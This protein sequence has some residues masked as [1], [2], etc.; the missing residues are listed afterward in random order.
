MLTG[1]PLFAVGAPWEI[2]RPNNLLGARKPLRPIDHYCKEGGIPGYAAIVCILPEYDVGVSINVAGPDPYATNMA[3][4]AA[5]QERLVPKLDELARE[6]ATERYVGKY[7]L[8]DGKNGSAI[9]FAV[10]DGPGLKVSEWSSR[11]RNMLVTIGA[12]FVGLKGNVTEQDVDVRA[13]PVG[14]GNRWRLF[15][16]KSRERR[17]GFTAASCPT[18]L[19]GVK[20]AVFVFLPCVF[21]C[22]DCNK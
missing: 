20:F 6:Q 16:G 12:Q 21:S 19:S 15:F 22:L 1:N 7:S 2:Y 8:P 18:W 10:D 14:I 11:G 3:L 4:V 17:E 13:F 9:R 5:V